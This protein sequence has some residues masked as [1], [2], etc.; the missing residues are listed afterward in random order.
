MGH[1][2]AAEWPSL[3]PLTVLVLFPT[4]VV[5][6]A[7]PLSTVRIAHVVYE[8]AM[9]LLLHVVELLRAPTTA[10]LHQYEVLTSNSYT[11]T[12]CHT[13]THFHST[14]SAA[15]ASQLT[16][17]LSPF[18]RACVPWRYILTTAL[19]TSICLYRIPWAYA[20]PGGDISQLRQS[21]L[22]TVTLSAYKQRSC[23][24]KCWCF[25]WVSAVLRTRRPEKNRARFSP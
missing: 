17:G 15:D 12:F 3:T 19:T 22:H 1:V 16:Q 14:T 7:S 23:H 18:P 20:E 11:D 21:P 25:T 4:V 2:I 8:N 10:L 9:L 24:L 13:H 5:T 6:V